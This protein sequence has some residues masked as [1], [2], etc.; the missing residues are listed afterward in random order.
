LILNQQELNDVEVVESFA[1]MGGFTQ[2]R[3]S[4]G[5]VLCEGQG[6]G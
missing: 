1:Q 2:I 3:K 5:F 6:R 4:I